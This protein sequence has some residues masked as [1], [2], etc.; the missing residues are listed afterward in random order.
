MDSENKS[1]AISLG[2]GSNVKLLMEFTGKSR[3]VPDPYFGREEGFD[4]CVKL[5]EEGCEAFIKFL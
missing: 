4:S 3:D 5:I 1:D 2:G